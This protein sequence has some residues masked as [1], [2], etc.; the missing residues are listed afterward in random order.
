MSK[1]NIKKGI[2]LVILV[3]L[4]VGGIK[5]IQKK[6]QELSQIPPP[7][8]PIHVVDYATIREGNFSIEKY[9]LGTIRAKVTVEIAP[10]VSGHILE[11]RGR[12]GDEVKKGD[13]LVLIDDREERDR[14]KELS[15]RVMAA[16]TALV[17]Q[18]KIFKRDEK[19][20]KE[21]AIS[22]EALDISKKAL[23]AARG[24]LNA[25]K[26]SLETARTALSYTRLVAPFDGVITKRVQNPG[27]LAIP[28]KTVLE[29]EA[30]D[31]GYYVEIKIPQDEVPLVFKGT[32][33]F[34]RNGHSKNEIVQY[35]SRIHPST[36]EG[37]LG[38]VE[39]DVA[40]KPFGLPTGAV[41]DCRIEMGEVYGFKVPLRSILENT[42]SSYLYLIGNDLRVHIK[43]VRVLFEGEDYAVVSGPG[44]KDGDRVV[45]AQE[46][47]LLRLHEGDKIK[48]S[49]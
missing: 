14:I 6:K 27:D 19:L 21:K 9:Y 32:R 33:V 4:V 8:E 42:N 34:L 24:E 20:F 30:T 26:A 43:K 37:T 3:V 2:F 35:V 22:Q 38:I 28:G 10:R 44:L 47:A 12:E 13:I 46:S 18:E 48:V 36:G 11:V 7:K 15:A 1:A 49:H 25:L 17:T 39:V 23:D 29:M 45:V 5:F 31:H 40:T 41:I 16:K